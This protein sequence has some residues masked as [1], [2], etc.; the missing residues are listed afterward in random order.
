MLFLF[1]A[2]RL[3]RR[4]KQMPLLLLPHP[5]PPAPPHLPLLSPWTPLLPL[6]LPR[7]PPRLQHNPRDQRRSLGPSTRLYPM[8]TF[9]CTINTS[10]VS[11]C[12]HPSPAE[13]AEMLSELRRVEERLQPFV[14]RAHTILETAT[15]TEYNN[16]TVRLNVLRKYRN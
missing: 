5:P 14:Q 1:R 15:N 12:S 9:T 10:N 3:M 8:A 6:P 13:L 7:L 16:N 4:P 2:T 11:F